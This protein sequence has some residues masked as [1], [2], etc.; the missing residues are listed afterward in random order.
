MPWYDDETNKPVFKGLDWTDEPKFHQAMMDAG[1]GDI[2]AS[3]FPERMRG[4]NEMEF[5]GVGTGIVDV[6]V[7]INDAN[8]DWEQAAGIHKDAYYNMMSK[9]FEHDFLTPLGIEDLRLNTSVNDGKHNGR[10]VYRNRVC[11]YEIQQHYLESGENYIEF[12]WRWFHHAYIVPN[13]GSGCV[14]SDRFGGPERYER[15]Y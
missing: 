14:R 9:L 15:H 2:V 10:A 5:Y 13:K 11:C 1:I 7:T 4:M 12:D 8:V 6:Y 3:G